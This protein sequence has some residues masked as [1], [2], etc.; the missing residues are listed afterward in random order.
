MVTGRNID[1]RWR[2][3]GIEHNT[4]K[5]G[6]VQGYAG[7][8]VGSVFSVVR[9]HGGGSGLF[10]SKDKLGLFK[11]S[12]SPAIRTY[13]LREDN[14]QLVDLVS[15]DLLDR[16]R[17]FRL[18]HLSWPDEVGHGHGWL[19][20]EYLDAVERTDEQLGRI[21]DT[22]ADTDRLRSTTALIV[23]SDHGGSGGGHDDARRLSNHRIP[24]LVWGR[25]VARGANLYGLNP[26]LG[27]PRQS[28]PGWRARRQPVRNADVANLALDMLGLPAVKGSRANRSQ[29]LDWR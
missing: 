3:H 29:G 24:F 15:A 14:A 6:T 19:G 23:T 26:D 10:V 25:G 27:R 11:R 22:I 13:A 21:V 1:R 18:V 7:H 8:G 9:R 2:G 20:P 5:P 17:A 12:W 4:A 28:R 16:H